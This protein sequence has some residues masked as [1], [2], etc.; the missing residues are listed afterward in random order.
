[1]LNK[2]VAVLHTG[3][4]FAMATDDKGTDRQNYENFS[5]SLNRFTKDFIDKNNVTLHEESVLNEASSNITK[6]NLFNLRKKVIELMT[7]VDGIVITHGTDTLEETAYFL[8]ITVSCK[9]PVVLI[10]AMR[11]INNEGSDAIKNFMSAIL[12]AKSEKSVG[13]GVLVLMNEEIHP[14]RSV[15]KT[16]TTN[17]NAFS[18]LDFGYI[19]KLYTNGRVFFDRELPN[20]KVYNINSFQKKVIL[21]KLTQGMETTIFD[22]LEALEF[23]NNI[24]SYD[25]IVVE[26]M[27]LGHVPKVIIPSLQRLEEKNIAILMATR[28][29]SGIV[30]PVYSYEGGLKD[31]KENKLKNLIFAGNINSLKARIKLEVLLEMGYDIDDIKNEFDIF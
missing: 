17:V 1:M 4:T 8:D 29:I 11:P 20:T 22:A 14:A 21:V 5:Q 6:E 10:G 28:C 23:K 3:G 15:I 9:V 25:G 24:I 13:K 16:H 31:L 30:Q 2:K 18:S 19:G 7:K 26:G 12:I 27:G